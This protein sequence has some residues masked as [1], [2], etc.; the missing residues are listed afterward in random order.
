ML[1]HIEPSRAGSPS[2]LPRVVSD[3]MSSS[4]VLLANQ[5]RMLPTSAP[6]HLTSANKQGWW[7]F[8]KAALLY[9]P[10]AFPVVDDICLADAAS[11]MFEI[12]GRQCCW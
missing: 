1:L 5:P 8:V 2:H 3:V 7:A 9:G 4:M 10:K 6:S 12:V 11:S